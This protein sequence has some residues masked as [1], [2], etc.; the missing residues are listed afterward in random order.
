[1]RSLVLRTGALLCSTP[2][3]ADSYRNCG[4]DW[5][6]AQPSRIVALNQHAADI[7]LAL[8]AGPALV[9]VAYLDD[10]DAGQ[11]QAEYFGVPVIARQYP[12]SEVLYAQQPDL[13]IGGFATAFGDGV[14]S[15]S[16][17]ARNGVGSYLLESACNG[18]S[19]DY[20]AHVRND[21]LTLGQAAAPAAKSPSV[22]RLHG[23]RPRQRP[24]LGSCG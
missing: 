7:V 14:T 1:M 19:L 15:R 23:N 4:E 10:T 3:L 2:V 20:F 9:G 24:C 5:S 11:R 13:V 21:L 16:G 12:A 6:A 22:D 8:G 17:L 18:H